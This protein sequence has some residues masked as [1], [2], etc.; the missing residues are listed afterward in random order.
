[1]WSTK[2][3]IFSVW[4]FSE[5]FAGSW[6]VEDKIEA[7][8]RGGCYILEVT[9]EMVEVSIHLSILKCIDW[10]SLYVRTKS[11]TKHEIVNGV[12]FP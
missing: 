2:P 12:I 5:K 4:S 10:T 6:L 7:Q 9:Q 8:R 1:M 3:K 11:Y